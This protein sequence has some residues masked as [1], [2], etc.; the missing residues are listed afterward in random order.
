MNNFPV[1]MIY[2]NCI[3]R[4]FFSF[5]ILLINIITLDKFLNKFSGIL[6]NLSWIIRILY[7]KNSTISSSLSIYSLSL[8]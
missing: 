5:F 8:F 2:R 1:T 4:S 3:I 7:L 6:I